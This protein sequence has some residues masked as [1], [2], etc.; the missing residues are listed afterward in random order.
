MRENRVREATE[1]EHR[2][3][4]VG[5]PA[6][7]VVQPVDE[8]VVVFERVGVGLQDKVA[9][10]HLLVLQ[11]IPVIAVDADENDGLK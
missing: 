7:H 11:Q 3:F 8:T 2:V 1:I 6:A 4:H 9:G 5:C 10:V